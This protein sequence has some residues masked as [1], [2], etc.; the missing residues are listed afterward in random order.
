MVRPE[1][2]EHT[3]EVDEDSRTGDETTQEE[4][5]HTAS[6]QGGTFEGGDGRRTL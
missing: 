3:E 1:E 6:E 4:P 5:E 2:D